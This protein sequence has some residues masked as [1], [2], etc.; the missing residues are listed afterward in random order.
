MEASLLTNKA[1]APLKMRADARTR[2]PVPHQGARGTSTHHEPVPPRSIHQR[3]APSP[4]PA[5]WLLLAPGLLAT[6]GVVCPRQC[7]PPPAGTVQDTLG[8]LLGVPLPG[9]RL[10]MGKLRWRQLRRNRLTDLHRLVM[11]PASR[12][13]RGGQMEPHIRFHQ[14]LR[15][16]LPTDIHHPEVILRLREPLGR[17]PPRPLRG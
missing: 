14:I 11:T 7:L 12:G 15:H 13:T 8:F 17:R 3:R 10:G 1:P 5:T 4:A 16:A 6:G 2:C 9:K